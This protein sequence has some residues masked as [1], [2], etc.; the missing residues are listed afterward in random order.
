MSQGA[1]KPLELAQRGPDEE[2]AELNRRLDLRTQELEGT[3]SRL[4]ELES[5]TGALEGAITELRAEAGQLRAERARLAAQLDTLSIHNDGLNRSL[6]ELRAEVFQLEAEGERNAAR[7][8]ALEGELTALEQE[9][10]RTV[11]DLRRLSRSFA[12]RLAHG[13]TRIARRLRMRPIVAGGAVEVLISRLEAPPAMISTDSDG[14]VE[15]SSE[16]R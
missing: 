12:W 5:A 13:L 1:P 16:T 7:L 3:V 8:R 11:Q 6:A 4:A 14:T 10:K 2:F 9:R 15:G